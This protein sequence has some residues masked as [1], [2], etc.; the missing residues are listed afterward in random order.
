ML[1]ERDAS[2]ELVDILC[3]LKGISLTNEHK[4]LGEGCHILTAFISEVRGQSAA[5]KAY[6]NV[7]GKARSSNMF[8]DT[9]YDA[10]WRELLLEVAKLF[11]PSDEGSNKNWSLFRL[12]D[13]CLKIPLDENYSKLFPNGENLLFACAIDNIYDEYA[14]LPIKKARN[15][16]LSHHDMSLLSKKEVIKI[17][18]AEVE[19]IVLKISSLLEIIYTHISIAKVSF[20]DYHELVSSYECSLRQLIT[21]KQI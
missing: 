5:V 13:M 6:W 8:L 15:K 9:A 18:F 1:E 17:S 2:Y 19:K 11:D 10:I 7:V 16:Q 3:C 4:E 20:L 14:V 12:R 21:E